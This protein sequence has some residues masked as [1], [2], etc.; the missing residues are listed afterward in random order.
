[1]QRFT[2]AID[3]DI[4]VSRQRIVFETQ[5]GGNLTR[6]ILDGT[7]LGSASDLVV[8]KP[9][10]G[11][12]SLSLLDDGGHFHDTIT[13]ESRLDRSAVALLHG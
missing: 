5:D 2:I 9:E 12:H 4:P 10:P 1:M 8:W 7:D 3:P 13:P 6:W 11:K